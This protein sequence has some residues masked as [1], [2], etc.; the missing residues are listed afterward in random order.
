MYPLLRRNLN[1]TILD[2]HLSKL[3]PNIIIPK[4][5]KYYK[6]TF[7]LYMILCKKRNELIKFLDKNSIEA[8]IHY[9]KPLHLQKASKI[10][11]YK[12]GDFPISEYQSLHLLTLP[13]HQYLNKNQILYTVNK[14][15]E[16]YNYG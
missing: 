16:F 13:V 15:K 10:F 8:K 6:E 3:E 14:I 9:P 12:K 4:R 7:S 1:A 5:L 2:F 11:K